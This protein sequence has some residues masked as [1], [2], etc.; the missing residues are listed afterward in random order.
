MV[1]WF[2]TC[3]EK[4]SLY[5]RIVAIGC[6]QQGTGLKKR[7]TEDEAIQRI[8]DKTDRFL[9]ERPAGHVVEVIIA[10]HEGRKYLKT[11][12]DGEIPDNLLALP[13]CPSPK[14]PIPLVPPTRSV[15]AAPS[16]GDVLS[17]LLRCWE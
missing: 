9:V 15:L 16:H 7:F 1:T 2:V 17:D 12:P 13:S 4:H 14:H 10:F 11:E 8:E 5:E 3:R 6:V